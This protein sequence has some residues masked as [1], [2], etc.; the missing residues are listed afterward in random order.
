[1]KDIQI[2]AA[3]LVLATAACT[4]S[5]CS[6]DGGNSAVPQLRV[7]T[8]NEYLQQPE[9][10]KRVF[11][12]CT[13][14]PGRKGDDPNCVNALRAERIAAAGTGRFPGVTP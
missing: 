9:L 8:V 10:R 3:M 7:I 13:D 4:G 11:T 1:M 2:V 14:D 5:G 12:A 6:K